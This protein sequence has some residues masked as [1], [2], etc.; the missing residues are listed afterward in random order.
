[1]DTQ[2]WER[3]FSHW[4][5]VVEGWDLIDEFPVAEFS[6]PILSV[7]LGLVQC[8]VSSGGP[9]QGIHSCTFLSQWVFQGGLGEAVNTPNT[10][11]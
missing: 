6:L 1:M 3:E 2:G 4:K 7:H 10:A 5:L 9:K 8:E 11:S